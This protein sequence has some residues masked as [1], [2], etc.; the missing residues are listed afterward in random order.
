MASL[1]RGSEH[2]GVTRARQDPA[3]PP[4]AGPAPTP[5][6]T[7]PPA[8]GAGAPPAPLVL[9]QRDFPEV[10]LAAAAN[11]RRGRPLRRR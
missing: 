10:M 1:G 4:G 5:A 8:G 7:P 11:G 6:P 9:Q 2:P 3:E